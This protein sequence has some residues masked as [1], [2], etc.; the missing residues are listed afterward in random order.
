MNLDQ[1]INAWLAPVADWLGK[2]VF[3]AVP[4]GGTALPL[5]LVWLIAGGI[6][7]GQVL[8]VDFGGNVFRTVPLILTDWLM[9]IGSTSLVLW[10]GDAGRV[11][12]CKGGGG[13]TVTP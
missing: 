4:V 11:G 9:L 13:K 1:A 7:L 5:I 6:V 12:A 10:L 8:L 3:F 2:V